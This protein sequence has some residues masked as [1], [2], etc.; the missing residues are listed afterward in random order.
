MTVLAKKYSA[1]FV[2]PGTELNLEHV[3]TGLNE[4]FIAFVASPE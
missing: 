4:Q 1:R 2:I 3:D